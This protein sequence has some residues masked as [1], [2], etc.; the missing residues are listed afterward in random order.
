VEDCEENKTY[1][2][3]ETIQDLKFPYRIELRR[4]E[5]VLFALRAQERWP[6][7][8]G[9]IFCLRESDGIDR[10]SGREIERVPVISFKRIG[11]RIVI[12]LDRALNKRCDFLFLKKAYQ[13]RPGEYEQIFWRTQAGLEARRPRSK[14]SYYRHREMAI[15][16]D[17]AERYAWKFPGCATSVSRLPAGDYALMGEKGVLAS[18]ERKTFDNLLA[19]F[20]RLSSFH[21]KLTEM[22]AYTHCA[23]VVE[24]SYQDFLNPAKQSFYPSDFCAKALAEI[25]SFHPKVPLVFAGGRKLANEWAFRFFESLSSQDEKKP[26][27]I[28]DGLWKEDSSGKTTGGQFFELREKVLSGIDGEFT[29]RT[30]LD[31]MPEAGPELSRRVLRSLRREGLVDVRG[32]GSGTVYRLKSPNAK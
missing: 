13:S 1:W 9:N 17:S 4:G 16:I 7:Q 30:L 31:L 15:V 8:K 24:A 27:S 10:Q 2:V 5:N 21:Q 14:L 23:L 20:G 18:V 19:E 11:L 6:G 12:V 26:D 32:K 29:S 28:P 25:Q 22:E 3:M